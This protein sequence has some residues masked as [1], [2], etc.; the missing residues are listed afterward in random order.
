MAV[1]QGHGSMRGMAVYMWCCVVAVAVWGSAG[2]G[3]VGGQNGRKNIFLFSDELRRLKTASASGGHHRLPSLRAES[4]RAVE[5]AQPFQEDTGPGPALDHCGL[6]HGLCWESLCLLS[7]KLKYQTHGHGSIFRPALPPPVPPRP[8]LWSVT[9]VVSTL[10]VQDPTILMTEH[11]RLEM[12]FLEIT[13][14]PAPL[15]HNP[16]PD[17]TQSSASHSRRSFP[18]ISSAL[19]PSTAL[20]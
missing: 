11:R 8:P 7:P 1:R 3:C 12:F 9:I 17:L 4:C 20:R 19:W 10:G 16:T 6:V 2:H 18:S 5:V 13:G 14:P 15:P